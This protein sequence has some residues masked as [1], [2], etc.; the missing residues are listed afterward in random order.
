MTDALPVQKIIFNNTKPVNKHMST[1][2]N[3]RDRVRGSSVI[4]RDDKVEQALRKFKK[5]IMESGL[6]QE[7]RERETYT[8]PTTK[9]KAN[10]AAAKRRWRKKLEADSLPKKM[11]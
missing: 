3:P 7:L 8:K 9:R 11:Y 5:K 10:R 2:N 1:F 6:L 4:V